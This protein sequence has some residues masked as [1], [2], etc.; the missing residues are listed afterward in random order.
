MD[1]TWPSPLLT[2]WGTSKSEHRHLQ[3]CLTFHPSEV[4]KMRT[5]IVGGNMLTRTRPE[6][7]GAFKLELLN[8]PS[9]K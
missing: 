6:D 9:S 5:Q 2:N 7:T 4:R 3:C 1:S 8:S